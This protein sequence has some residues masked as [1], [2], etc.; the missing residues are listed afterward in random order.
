MSIIDLM[1]FISSYWLPLVAGIINFIWVYLEYKASIWLWPVGIV[2]PLFYIAVSWEA[3]YLGNIVIN[4]YYF[5]TSIIGWWMWIKR[6]ASE[7]APIRHIRRQEVI[8]ALLALLVLSA[9][10]Y[11][12]LN[13]YSSMPALD[14]LATAASFIGMVLLSRQVAEQWCCWIFANTLSTIIFYHVGDYITA[15]V[16]FVN[17]IVSILG[18]IRWLRLAQHSSDSTQQIPS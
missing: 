8:L 14:A 7:E 15:L 5:I 13:G 3:L 18:L 17:L 12:L 11:M 16:F 9:P 10:A 2:L 1:S 6:G 4:V